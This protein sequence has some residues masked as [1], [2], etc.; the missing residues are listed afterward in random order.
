MNQNGG[1]SHFCLVSTSGKKCLCSA[2]FYLQDDGKGCK[3]NKSQP[4]I[5]HLSLTKTE[6]R[7]LETF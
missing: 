1:C 3:G 2:G 4:S 7:V 5:T 6:W